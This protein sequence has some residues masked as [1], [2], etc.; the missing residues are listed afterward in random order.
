MVGVNS[1]SLSPA[2]KQEAVTM[3]ETTKID[4]PTR[5]ITQGTN[6]AKGWENKQDGGH[7]PETF[8][9]GRKVNQN[10]DGSRKLFWKK[11]S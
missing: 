7:I 11:V 5:R 9:F 3:G 2:W 8:T 6:I 10:V 4:H 1:A